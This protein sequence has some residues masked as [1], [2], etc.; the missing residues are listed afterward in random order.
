[1]PKM[2]DNLY[3]RH[4]QT[5]ASYRTLTNRYYPVFFFRSNSVSSPFVPVIFFCSAAVVVY[6]LLRSKFVCL[7]VSKCDV[8]IIRQAFVIVVEDE[9]VFI[10]H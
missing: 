10:R 8:C 7:D 2:V 3:G 9:N 1:M 5:H 6:I 4:R